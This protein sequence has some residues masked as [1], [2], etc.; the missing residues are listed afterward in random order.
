MKDTFPQRPEVSDDGIGVV[1]VGDFNPKIYQPAWFASQNLL[2]A[3]EAESANIELIHP[4]FT[5]FSTDV[6]VMQVTRNRFLLTTK[7]SAYR[8]HLKDLVLGTFRLLAHTPLT[9]MGINTWVRVRFRNDQD[10]HRFGHFLLPKSPWEGLL[11]KPGTSFVSVRGARLDELAG[12]VEVTAEPVRGSTNEVVV[13]V[14]DHCER[15]SNSPSGSADFFLDI[16]ERDYDKIISRSR[17]L[18]DGVLERFSEQ[19]TF[20][21][22]V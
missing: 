5:S 7:S 4:D 6:L 10:W 17:E 12:W 9:Q 1:L 18:M 20:D 11:A 3:S 8:S 13:R 21:D 19:R 14:N 22:G 2:R 15:S 16:I